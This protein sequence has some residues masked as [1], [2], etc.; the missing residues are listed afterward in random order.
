M[1]G[2]VT[3]CGCAYCVCLLG[4]PKNLLLFHSRKALLWR[5]NIAG[6][7]K[8]Y[9]DLHVTCPILLPE[10]NQIW[11]FMTDFHEDPLCKVSRN[12]VE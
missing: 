2:N 7:K 1:I 6:N 5:F 10:F 3:F 11:I 4:Y 9:L 12:S 8:V